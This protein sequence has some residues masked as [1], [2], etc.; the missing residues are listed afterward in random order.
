MFVNSLSILFAICLH[1]MSGLLLVNASCHLLAHIFLILGAFF[2]LF[3]KILIAL[4]SIL[5]ASMCSSLSDAS[6]LGAD[7]VR[8]MTEMSYRCTVWSFC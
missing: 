3:R 2:P 7:I 5:I 8:I 1:F 6:S 4:D